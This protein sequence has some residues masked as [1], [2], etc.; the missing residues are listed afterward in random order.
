MTSKAVL[1]WI[2]KRWTA[3]ELKQMLAEARRC[4]PALRVL[5]H[6][7]CRNTRVPADI[8]VTKK[9]LLVNAAALFRVSRG[10]PND[11][12]GYYKEMLACKVDEMPDKMLEMRAG[13]G[14]CVSEVGGRATKRRDALVKGKDEMR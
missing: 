6:K 5:V 8:P 14:R 7:S 13:R 3:V 4:E 9:H 12:D 1:A 10:G 2:A 11:G